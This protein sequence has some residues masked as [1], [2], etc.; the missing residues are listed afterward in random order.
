ME[1]TRSLPDVRFTLATMGRRASPGP[2]AEVPE[3]VELVE[4]DPWRDVDAAGDWLLAL[5]R[6]TNADVVHLNGYAHGALP[7]RA[8][9]LVVAH[10]CV[11]SWW[12]AV[13]NEDA[14]GDWRAYRERVERGLASATLIATPS[15]HMLAALDE[16]YR[17]PTP[18]RLIYNGRR[19]TPSTG[20]GHRA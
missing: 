1:L 14:P 13:K 19:F 7:F 9:K 12:R 15:A 2:R 16:S 20:H 18:R 5:E 4:D 17:F 8:R 11:M 6:D 10:S 3:N